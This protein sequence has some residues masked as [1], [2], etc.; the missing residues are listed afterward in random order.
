MGKRSSKAVRIALGKLSSGSNTYDSA[1]DDAMERIR[2]QVKDQEDLA[3]Q[4]LS[5]ITCAMRPLTT[6]ELQHALAVEVGD[7]ELDGDNIPDIDDMVS[8]CAGL[9]TVDEESTIIRLVHY[10]TQEYFEKTQ[11]RWFPGGHLTITNVCTTYLSFL[12]FENGY[13]P[14]I[15]EFKQR[16]RLNPFYEYSARNWGAHA[17][18]TST[19]DTVIS[20]LR[21][22]GQVDAAV[23]GVMADYWHNGVRC[24]CLTSKMTGLHLAAYYGLEEAVKSLITE[25]GPD[26]VDVYGETPLACSARKGRET[27]AEIL[28]AYGA[29]VNARDHRGRTPLSRAAELGHEPTVELPLINGAEVNSSDNDNQT[30]LSQAVGYGHKTVVK[31]LLRVEKINVNFKDNTGHTALTGAVSSKNEAITKMLLGVE[32]TDINSKDNAGRTS[33]MQAVSNNHEAITTMLLATNGINPNSMDDQNR[34]PLWAATR[35]GNEALVKQLLAAGADPNLKDNNGYGPLWYAVC[36]RHVPIIQSLL[37]KGGVDVNSKGL[38]DRTPLYEAVST[39]LHYEIV[40][41][42][43]DHGA[44]INAA[45]GVGR[46]ALHYAAER[47]S[48]KVVRLLIDRGAD[49]HAVDHWADTALHGAAHHGLEAVVKMLIDEGID[50]NATASD[51]WTPLRYTYARMPFYEGIKI[52]TL[53]IENGAI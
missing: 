9:V 6:V 21:K 39:R 16:L 15:E 38:Y 24:H 29:E 1:Y 35:N 44:D 26:V 3:M 20:F 25:D 4:V 14:T 30:P 23:Q 46:T 11:L 51:R 7:S 40:R 12:K 34:T 31:L 53:L 28:C 2:G 42:L 49:I 37:A 17:R 45:N 18:A 5:W 22:P 10:T 48:K 47:S 36:A 33:L 27:A 19:H 43:I 52:R 32:R 8:V 13:C 50:V 41:L